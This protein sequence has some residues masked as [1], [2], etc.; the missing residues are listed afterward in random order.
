MSAWFDAK[1]DLWTTLAHRLTATVTVFLCAVSLS[2]PGLAQSPGSD[3]VR[4][5]SV[6]SPSTDPQ[7]YPPDVRRQTPEEESRE[8]F[9][10]RMAHDSVA[11][12]IQKDADQYWK[13]A[14]SLSEATWGENHPFTAALLCRFADDLEEQNRYAEAASLLR[15]ALE[16]RKARLAP[17]D[18]DTGFVLDALAVNLTLQGKVI[19]AEP[20]Y[21]QSLAIEDRPT[22][23]QMV[24]A[25]TLNNLA[26]DLNDQGIS[27]HEESQA[28]ERQGKIQDAQAR[29]DEGHRHLKESE[30]LLRR[31]LGIYENQSA[32]DPLDVKSGLDNLAANLRSQGRNSEAA[33]LEDRSRSIEQST[34][35]SAQVRTGTRPPEPGLAERSALTSD[36]P[37]DIR[38]WT[39]EEEAAANAA[40]F[41]AREL[42]EEGDFRT[43]EL[44]L[45]KRLDICESSWGPN[46]PVTTK[47][48]RALGNNLNHQGRYSEA[49]SQ[50]RRA[51]DIDQS[52][53]RSK[54]ADI[55]LDAGNLATILTSL[56]RFEDAEVLL[57][58]A[59]ALDE[60]TSPQGEQVAGDLNNLGFNLDYQD[61]FKDAEAFFRRAL[62]LTRQL[63][64]AGNSKV[65]GVLTNLAYNLDAQHRYR[66]AEPFYRS[67]LRIYQSNPNDQAMIATALDNLGVNLDK[68]GEHVIAEAFHREA[69]RVFEG[70]VGSGHPDFAASINNLAACLDSQ[71]RHLDAEKLFE[72]ALTVNTARLGSSHPTTAATL[73]NL[74]LE[75]LRLSQ[76]QQA[77]KHAEQA[78]T[79]RLELQTS[80]APSSPTAT[81]ETYRTVSTTA[82]FLYARAAWG[83][84]RST[85]PIPRAQIEK[86]F[87][88]AQSIRVSSSADA[89][90][91]A[92][93]RTAAE[94]AGG[95]PTLAEWS[96]AM[97]EVAKLDAD[98][99]ASAAIGSPRDS[100]RI[101]LLAKRD[102][103]WTRA[104]EVE[105]QLKTKFPR[106][107]DLLQPQPIT[108]SELQSTTAGEQPLLKDNEVLVLLTPGSGQM[109]A[110]NRNGFVFA[111]SRTAV[112]W[113][114]I[115][116]SPEV[117]RN[118]IRELHQE[119]ER[120]G[121][122]AVGG[123]HSPGIA[124]DRNASFR[125]YEALF[126]G[127]SIK[128]VV[129]RKERWILVPQGSLVS[130]P[131]A[132]LVTQ[133]PPENRDGDYDPA[134]LRATSWLGLEKILAEV[135]SVSALKIQRL[136]VHYR[137]DPQ[138]TPFFG[139]GDPAYTGKADTDSCDSDGHS[140]PLGDNS[141]YVRSGVANLAALH[142]LP[143]L[144]S[145]ASE[146]RGIAE[147]LNAGRNSYVLQLDATEEEI[148]RRNSDHS[149]RR[150]EVIAFATHGLIAGDL[151][152]S[153]AEP[154]LALTPPDLPLGETPSPDND[155]LL[156]AS[157]VATLDLNARFV[158][159]SA[160]DTASGERDDDG[161][162]GLAR[163]FFYAGAES[164]LV[165][166]FAVFDEAARR[167]TTATIRYSKEQQL[168]T[169]EALRKAMIDLVHDHA[170]DRFGASYAQPSQ[171]APFIAIDAY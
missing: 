92:S 111:I 128:A 59:L 140:M 63:S 165:S 112:A 127:P 93:A 116:L 137:P 52:I 71:G 44:F 163:A 51:L 62:T 86:A 87:E 100:L 158:I 142:S 33:L 88:A 96:T 34:A 104:K 99:S 19:E 27:E 143:C 160:C 22:A 115:R 64:N 41:S 10:L 70:S 135:P 149:L 168:H 30:A 25:T 171:W 32:P 12:H 157:E 45:R 150:A 73:M 13:Q 141:K 121:I 6:R 134:A 153:L 16:I 58:R 31:A 46:H 110:G 68:E 29:R 91:S 77:Q 60:Q 37:P 38:A 133:K 123:R 78:L 42:E 145:S 159:L 130:L 3:V 15:R 138:T 154:A 119:L 148:R 17:G 35:S 95:G 5:F 120:G 79:A 83:N 28:L 72:R 61:R 20:F 56:G 57:R 82:A 14:I 80:L 4:Q 102:V 124:F 55:A 67:A 125:L 126:G 139:V 146:I 161:L 1:K 167:L 39:P 170:M 166:H 54:S 101:E 81:M 24:L 36:N 89:L 152:D 47:A 136:L 147:S 117:L 40:S 8:L 90:A 118:T 98:I 75:E 122:T 18:V 65:A 103:A 23:N 84:R 164:L 105:A 131:F 26:R 155:G 151:P 114:E 129:S 97:S 132:T 11:A 109:P 94:R 49:E 7:S 21:R 108:L 107:F 50:Y 144:P 43:A 162:S 2:D 53:P 169:P 69:I 66:E 74:A 9:L 156:T 76:H 113:S 48:L 106:Y 85:G